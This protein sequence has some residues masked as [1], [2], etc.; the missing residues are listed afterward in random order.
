[1][2]QYFGLP[3]SAQLLLMLVLSRM[4]SQSSST[5][6]RSVWAALYVHCSPTCTVCI[7][8]QSIGFTRPYPIKWRVWIHSDVCFIFINHNT[9]VPMS[10]QKGNTPPWTIFVMFT[11]LSSIAIDR[12]KD[13][14]LCI[15]EKGALSWRLSRFYFIL[16]INTATADGD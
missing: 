7:H 16:I 15:F 3:T 11:C 9:I 8:N 5:T 13:H 2:E 10:I 4:Y 14:L 6:F 12:S 1:M